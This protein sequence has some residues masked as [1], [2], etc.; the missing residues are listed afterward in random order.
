MG[1]EILGLA[2]AEA[3]EA[4]SSS[5][6]EVTFEINRFADWKK[7][8]PEEIDAVVDFS[9]P[10][11]SQQALAWAME[12]SR[13]IV[14]GT[15]GLSKPELKSFARAAKKIPVLYSANMSV[16]IAVFSAMLKSL[17]AVK[18][19]NFQVEEAHHIHKKDRP[20]GTAILLQAAL[21]QAV[22]RKLPEPNCIRGGGIPGIHQVWAMG[23]EET[24]ILQHTAFQRTVFARGAIAAARWLFDKNEPGLYDLSHLY[25]L[26]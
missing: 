21:A 15:T 11:G 20:S 26:N 23:P 1:Q 10:K 24:L 17:A 4:G 8:D 14:S 25:S 6:I 9:N 18:D 3:K 12:N 13:P 2:A 7:A 19:W 16:G 5:R 22:A